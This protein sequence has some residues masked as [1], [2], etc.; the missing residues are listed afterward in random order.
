MLGWTMSDT[1]SHS[2]IR[3]DAHLATGEVVIDLKDHRFALQPEEARLLYAQ[4]LG[5]LRVLRE[6]GL[7]A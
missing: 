1:N 4:I 6:G 5:A 3:A 2:N 7:Y